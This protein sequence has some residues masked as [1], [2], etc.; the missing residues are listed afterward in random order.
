M[1]SAALE[2]KKLGKLRVAH[3]RATVSA[4]GEN[5]SGTV[6]LAA[7]MFACLSANNISVEMIAQGASEVNMSAVVKEENELEAI[8]A[9][10]REFMS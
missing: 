1:Q 9:L 8:H 10:H 6:G 4:V 7:R 2:L 5:M 3:N